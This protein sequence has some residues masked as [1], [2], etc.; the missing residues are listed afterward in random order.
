MKIS[1][2]KDLL[3]QLKAEK[4]KRLSDKIEQFKG[5]AKELDL[6]E[7][8]FKTYPRKTIEELEAS[9]TG[10]RI[11]KGRMNQMKDLTGNPNYKGDPEKPFFGLRQGT[12]KPSEPKPKRAKFN[13]FQLF[14]KMRASSTEDEKFDSDCLI[15]RLYTNPFD[16]IGRKI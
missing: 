7:E 13:T 8:E 9:I 15:I 16:N 5:L 4:A 11:L 12:K 14:D 10:L 1:E 6:T 3:E 2:E